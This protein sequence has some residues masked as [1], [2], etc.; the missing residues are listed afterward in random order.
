[1]VMW[2]CLRNL[3]GGRKQYGK[4]LLQT[5]PQQAADP[6]VGNP[7]PRMHA[8]VIFVGINTCA[9]YNVAKE[10]IEMKIGLQEDMTHEVR[11]DKINSGQRDWG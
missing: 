10:T 2:L 7:Q 3:H 8:C 4:D 5:D 6:R 11:S 9:Q 1:M